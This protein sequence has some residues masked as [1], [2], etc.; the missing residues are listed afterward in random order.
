MRITLKTKIWLTILTIVLMFSFFTFL[1]FPAR[2][3]EYLLKN[4]NNEVQNL[5]K[6]VAVGVEIAINEQNFKG[7][8]KEIEI[9][10]N[11][12]R[13]SFVSLL[14]EDTTWTGKPGQ[15]RIHDTVVTSFPENVSVPLESSIND[16][17]IIKRASLNTK[18]MNGNGAIMLAF[19]T[20]EISQIRKRLA[21]VSFIAS[22]VV[23]LLAILV[24]FW[25]S[26]N[27]SKPILALRE[28][29]IGVGE[30][31]LDQRVKKTT[32]DEIGDLTEAFNK[33]VED[34]GKARAE[35]KQANITLASTNEA[36]SASMEDLKEAQDQLL[37]SEKMASLGQLTAGIAHEINN[38]INFVSANITPLKEDLA[39][40]V[41]LLVC[42][43]K[44]IREKNLDVDF[45]EAKN[46]KERLHFDATV[47]EVS[48]LLT[49]IEDGARRTSEIVKGLRNFSR[50]DQNV[51]KPT[52][53]NDCL[54]STLTL[55]HSSYKNKV[56]I[57]TN[58]GDLPDV[59]CFPGQINQV[60]MNIL[61]NAVQ[62]IPESGKI[63]INTRVMGD[64]VR[65][66]VKDTGSGMSEEVRKKIYD[67]FFTTKD[68]G[69][70]TGLGLYISYGI[71][72]KHNGKIE[73]L[74][75]VGEGTEFVLTI[76]IHQ[77]L[78]A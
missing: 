61:S 71:I 17:L 25:L 50:A 76:P 68:V 56:E 13:L 12:P 55:L 2:Q 74:S 60:F 20:N 72:E 34:L 54:E 1:Y 77:Q 58:Y 33:M 59:D 73:V 47:T 51:F 62:S 22:T 5:A 21:R 32:G 67:P 65:V 48:K 24:G 35:L 6:T 30:G 43:D 11:D 52:N 37:Q 44:I 29:A 9:V 64:L 3:E 42:Y 8:K 41:K 10:K 23:L 16:T 18:L 66:S 38:P 45:T 53:L 70:G 40:I 14:E 69:K 49:G 7:I 15:Y 19:K 4:Y 63:F 57:V 78:S 26:R 31:N 27:I 36:L 39:D 75:T 46:L 28:A